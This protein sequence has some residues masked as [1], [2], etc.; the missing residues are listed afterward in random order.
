MMV[1][2]VRSCPPHVFC[3]FFFLMIRRPPRSTLFPYTTLFRS[4]VDFDHDGAL[5][6]AIVNGR[7]S[8]GTPGGN[9]A[10]NAYWND[11]AERNQL[12]AN[13]STGKFRDVSPSND[14]FCGTAW[15][16]RGLT[17]GDING[18]GALDLLVTTVGGPALLYRNCAP[19]RGHWFMVRAIDPALHRDA[20][21][22]TITI[23]AIGRRWVSGIYPGQSYLCSL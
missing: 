14:P 6:L 9:S 2:C 20:Y 8:R 17:C 11:Y 16:S 13:D 4:L 21:G 18:D 10:L 22:A 23:E 3:S 12:F 15:I 1:L 19:K 5:D 7:V